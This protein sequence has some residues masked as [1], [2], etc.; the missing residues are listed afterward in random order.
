M[1]HAEELNDQQR[2][3]IL[4]VLL[5][6][7]FMTLVAVS[8]IAVALPAI[9]TGLGASDSELQWVLAGYSLPFGVILVASG[10]AGDLL[11]RE[12]LFKVGILIFGLASLAA[13]LAPSTLFLNIA[14]VIMGIGSGIANPQITGIIQYHYQG[15][16]R[17]KAF[18]L[19]GA[20][21]GTAVAIGPLVGG[22]LIGWLPE[23]IGWRSTLGINVPLSALTV[24]LAFAW[25]PRSSRGHKHHDLD[26]IGALILGA[27]VF[28]IM[29]PFI[30]GESQSLTWWI[31]PVGVLTIGGWLAWEVH[32]HRAGKSPMVDLNLFKIRS[33][34]LGTAMITVQFL[35]GPIVW[36]LVAQFVQEG[37][38]QSALVSGLIALPAS[39][40]SIVFAYLGGTLIL[41]LGR[42]LIIIGLLIQLTG[43]VLTAAG[44][45]L[46]WNGGSVWILALT[47]LPIGMGAAW[48]TAPNK[49]LSLRHVPRDIGGTAGA[50]M[51]T[52]QRIATSIGTAAVTG[53]Y[54][55]SLNR[56]FA[57]ALTLGLAVISTF[58][59]IA[60]ILS[61]IDAILGRDEEY[62]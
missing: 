44:S 59:I 60:L 10:R 5:S 16:A 30:T 29:L 22:I 19:F 38:G 3:R 1:T 9:K 42:R 48:V 2:R 47:T 23:S 27:A 33:F 12:K 41:R 25:L 28:C 56:G 55:T 58:T 37:M 15:A 6:A 24:C 34:S 17:A 32:Y 4:V 50:I 54:F 53:I 31:L 61:V 62:A 13:A 39:L 8:I 43:V 18:A 21:V 52:G 35:G 26:P 51:Q 20:V 11:G 57:T 7:L 49:T 14:R 36:I 45:H 46:V 40:F